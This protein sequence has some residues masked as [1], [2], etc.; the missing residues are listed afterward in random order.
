[1]GT[2]LCSDVGPL[3]LSLPPLTLSPLTLSLRKP[4]TIADGGEGIDS[5]RASHRVGRCRT[6]RWGPRC[7][8]TSG[9]YPYRSLPSLFL[10]ANS[11]QLP[12]G[13]GLNPSFGLQVSNASVGTTLCSDGEVALTN[14]TFRTELGPLPLLQANITDL[15]GFMDIAHTQVGRWGGTD[16][17]PGR[18]VAQGVLRQK[19]PREMMGFGIPNP[20]PQ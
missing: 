13:Q 5:L 12:T 17:T 16:W 11:R 7:A 14:V 6:R 15:W 4:P 19:R 18:S 9:L 10:C 20:V 2:T 1:V 3:S 8:P